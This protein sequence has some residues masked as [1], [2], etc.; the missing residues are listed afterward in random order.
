MTGYTVCHVTTND[1]LPPLASIFIPFLRLLSLTRTMEPT[2]S[3]TE[4]S[5]YPPMRV[6]VQ[7]LMH[8]V[9]GTDNMNKCDFIFNRI[10]Q[11]QWNCDFEPGKVHRCATYNDVFAFANRCYFFLLDVGKFDNDDDVPV[12]CYEWTEES[13]YKN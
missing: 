5:E 1:S 3:K 6:L 7:T 11:H 10:C 8:L 4:G 12:I 2:T 9:S 13:L